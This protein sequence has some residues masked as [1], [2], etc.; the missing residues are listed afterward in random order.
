MKD[1]TTLDYLE[2][3][4]RIQE[5]FTDWWDFDNTRIA[6]MDGKKALKFWKPRKPLFKAISKNC[7][8]VSA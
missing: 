8:K 6:E 5:I 7:S 3:C 4:R 2:H 1:Q